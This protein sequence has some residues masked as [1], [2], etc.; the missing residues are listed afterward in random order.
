MIVSIDYWPISTILSNAGHHQV[1]C[2]L[3][4]R[5]WNGFRSQGW[6]IFQP[7]I[8]MIQITFIFNLVI[9]KH[10][11][12]ECWNYWLDQHRGL[13]GE[14]WRTAGWTHVGFPWENPRPGANATF[15]TRNWIF[16]PKLPTKHLQRSSCCEWDK[17][18]W[19]TELR[20]QTIEILDD[21]WLVENL[22]PSFDGI[23][24]ASPMVKQ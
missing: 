6:P 16:H 21:F 9:L 20:T 18:H 14:P 2:Q 12:P 4:V 8:S 23:G 3:Q 22:R 5:V 7:G 10:N 1:Y 19:S 11:L 24:V 17:W 15:S 13:M